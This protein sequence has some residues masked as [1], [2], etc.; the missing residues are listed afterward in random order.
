MAENFHDSPLGKALQRQKELQDKIKSAT[1]TIKATMQELEKLKQFIDTYRSFST[2]SESTDKGATDSL[3]ASSPVSTKLRGHAHGQTQAVFEA[4]VLD[5]LR[6]VGRPMKSNELIE[7]FKKRGQPLGGNEVRTAWNRLWQARD[8]GVLTSDV[9]V[10]YW[11]AGEPLSDEAKQRALVAARRTR[12]RGGPS[13][14]DLTRGKRKGPPFA[15]TPEKVETIE[16]LLLSGKSR[17][18]VTELFGISLGTLAKYV[19]SSD[20]LQTKYPDVVIPKPVPRPSRNKRKGR[21]RV[22]TAEKV[23]Q[24]TKMKAEGKSVKEITKALSLKQS[25]VYNFLQ[26]LEKSGEPE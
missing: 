16:R 5:I 8:R 1:D 19:G 24:L 2:T 14:R 13:L 21:P 7:E 23:E 18:E 17:K 9:S 4:L 10:G 26:K 6:D 20:A 15:L 12:K 25:T 3:P 11:I 22:L